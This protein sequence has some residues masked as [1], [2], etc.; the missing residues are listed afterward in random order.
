LPD[1]RKQRLLPQKAE[2]L[3]MRDIKVCGIGTAIALLVGGPAAAETLEVTVT[4]VRSGLGTLRADLY[5]VG[6]K[7]VA[8]QSEVAISGTL[9]LTFAGI[10]PGH[11][12]VMLYHDENSNGRLDRGGPLGMP[13]EGYAF[14]R[15][16]PVRLGPPSFD[17]M[18]VNVPAGGAST[19]V[20]MR[21]P[22]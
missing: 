21:Y 8:K 7:H 1:V 16:A 20:R 10:P 19:A 11:Y 14:S 6:R 22:Q 4:G 17:S 15:D 5:A 9:R 2:D 13:T 3:E 12:A 18:R